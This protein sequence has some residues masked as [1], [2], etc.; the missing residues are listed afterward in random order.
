MSILNEQQAPAIVGRIRQF[1]PQVNRVADSSKPLR[2][3]VKECDIKNAEKGAEDNCA[4]AHALERELKCD[5]AIVRPKV[6]Y[7]IRGNL[8]VKYSVPESVAR[9]IV[10]FDRNHDF[11]AG[12]YQLTQVYPCRRMDAQQKRTDKASRKHRRTVRRPLVAHIT[13]GIRGVKPKGG[14]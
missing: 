10:S 12:E 8:A 1:F 6:A 3:V 2:V 11:R 14:V 7:I 4:M 9:E 5:G 13:Q